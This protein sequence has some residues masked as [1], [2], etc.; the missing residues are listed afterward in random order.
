MWGINLWW[1]ETYVSKILTSLLCEVLIYFSLLQILRPAAATSLLVVIAIVSLC[2]GDVMEIQTALT[3]L[4]KKGVWLSNHASQVAQKKCS[5][6]QMELASKVTG[7]VMEKKIVLMALM[8]KDAVSL[9]W[10]L[11]HFSGTWSVPL[12]RENGK[13]YRWS[14]CF[15]CDIG[16][17]MFYSNIG[18]EM[19]IV[20][21][22]V[23]S[24]YPETPLESQCFFFLLLFICLIYKSK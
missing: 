24:Y 14:A 20:C 9:L 3:V 18:E 8:S 1:N 21:G 2:A 7:A 19:Q 6:V 15:I 12:N 16:I 13:T 5:V 22:T 23:L 17:I 10:I 4:M 11:K